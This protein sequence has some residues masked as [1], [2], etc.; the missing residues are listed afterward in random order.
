MSSREALTILKVRVFVVAA[1]AM[2]NLVLTV[3]FMICAVLPW[4]FVPLIVHL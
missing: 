4:E 3:N 2:Y 1:A